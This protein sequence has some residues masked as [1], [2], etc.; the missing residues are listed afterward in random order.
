[1]TPPVASDPAEELSQRLAAAEGQ[2]ALLKEQLTQTQRL[3]TI[4]T[5]AAVIAHEFNNILTPVISYSQFALQSAES[6]TPDLALIRKALAKSFNGST[7]AGKVC[8]SLLGLVR[9]ESDHGPIAVQQLV[10]ETLSVMARD[11][12]RDGIA[13]RLQVQPDCLVHGDAVQLEQVLLNL[14][15][16]AQQAMAAGGRGGSITVRASRDAGRVTLTVADT[17]PGIAEKNLPRVLSRSSPPRAPPER[18][19]AEAPG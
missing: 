11:P 14:L 16:N 5:I 17:G 15:I 3:A 18:V 6:E 19:R 1:V 4:G 2:L 12:Q 7:K 8:A 10:D 9:G 13:L